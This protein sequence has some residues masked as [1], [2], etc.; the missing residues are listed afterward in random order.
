MA[1]MIDLS[2]E[3]LDQC[4]VNN[5]ELAM[6]HL[7]SSLCLSAI[8]HGGI[9]DDKARTLLSGIIRQCI[10]TLEADTANRTMEDAADV[11]A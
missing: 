3:Q 10:E 11:H 7:R 8:K 6:A 1:I 9:L 4:A 5:S 2:P